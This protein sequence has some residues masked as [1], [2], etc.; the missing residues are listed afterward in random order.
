[1]REPDTFSYTVAGSF[2]VTI[3][4]PVNV[5]RIRGSP[6]AEFRGKDDNF[7]RV[8]E[9]EAVRFC[10]VFEGF[11]ASE[12]NLFDEVF[13]RSL[14]EFFT[15]FSIKVDVIDKEVTISDGNGGRSRALVVD[16]VTELAEFE[17][18]ADIMVLYLY[19]LAFAIFIRI[20]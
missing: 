3:E 14:S 13:M 12:L 20:S 16:E 17:F 8:V 18:E 6:F 11:S 7:R 15:F 1:L 19:T 2:P 5:L 9:V 4:S 10:A